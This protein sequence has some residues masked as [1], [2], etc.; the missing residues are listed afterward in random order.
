[1]KILI[2]GGGGREH[3][4][5]WKL[6]QSPSVEKIYWA[7][8]N[9]NLTDY[10]RVELSGNLELA[11]FALA[12]D[13]DLTV[14]GPEAPLCEG[15]VDDFRERNLAIFGP[16]KSAAQLEGS[17]S[18]AKDFMLRHQIPTAAH[19]RFT[20]PEQASEYIQKKGA[21]I[22]VK[23]DGLAAGKGV[24]VAENVE[25]ALAA[26]RSCF[27]GEFGQAGES[28]LIEECL[29]GEEASIIALVDGR[30]I[31]PLASSQD[32]KR[33]GENDTGANTGGMG[34]YSPA[35][36]VEEGL[37]PEIEERI[38]KPFLKGCRDENLDFRGVIYAGIMVTA[39]G[40]KVL[41]FNVRLGDPE[42]QAVLP[43]LKSDLAEVMLAVTQGKL[44]E[45]KLKWD[46]RPASCVVMAAE[47][48]PGRYRKGDPISG[49]AEAESRGALVFHAG[50]DRDSA[51]Q[52]VTA[53]G[54]VLGVTAL[55]DD[56]ADAL[57]KN[58]QAV[59]AIHWPGAYFRRD[60]GFRALKRRK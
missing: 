1:M 40:V 19:A 31:L 35:P 33:A 45:V 49:I 54:R 29:I 32:H 22:V 17:K 8:G 5:A 9:P 39:D 51:G 58:Y 46:P 38:L 27:S 44:H 14:V 52:P 7:P 55:G 10:Q 59:E 23:A 50:T 60:I 12:N 36:V 48:Y 15:I 16:D 26:V 30:S 25:Q 41:E 6:K 4:L 47:G 24:I 13:I 43:R 2:L 20:N 57:K 42:T 34:A 28:V 11:E 21:P 56:L 18:F 37:W 3:A 53:G